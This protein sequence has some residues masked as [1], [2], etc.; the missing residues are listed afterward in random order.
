MNKTDYYETD[1]LVSQ[2]CEFHFGEE[3]FGVKNFPLNIVDIANKYAINKNSVLDIG[4]SVGRVS[5]ELTKYFDKVVGIDYSSKF[6]EAANHLKDNKLIKFEKRIEGNIKQKKEYKLDN[7]D[8]SKVS[9]FEGDACSLSNEYKGFD[10]II[11]INLLDRLHTPTAFLED[12]TQRL[13]SDGIFIVASPFTWMEEYV[14]EENW[15]GGKIVDG[16]PLYSIENLK[17]ILEKDFI[18]LDEPFDVEF[19]IQEH[20]RKFQHTF[21]TFS[22]WKKR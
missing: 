9:F 15:L 3:Y 5:F 12:I 16:K 19:V 6:I 14:K 13:N 20:I 8:I 10:M 21:S 1:E 4:C 18:L 7:I 2:Y 22:I 11:A 17:K